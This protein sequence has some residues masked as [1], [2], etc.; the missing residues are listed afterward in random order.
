MS[1]SKPSKSNDSSSSDAPA[2]KKKDTTLA[3]LLFRLGALVLGVVVFFA[4]VGWFL[5][6]EYEVSTSIEIDAPPADVYALIGEAR[7]WAK[8]SPSW[9]FPAQ[10]K[11]SHRYFDNPP[12][13]SWQIDGT[14]GSF[15]RGK[16][17]FSD[18]VENQKVE[19]YV[20]RAYQVFN[21][22]ELEPLAD[23]TRTRVT[24]TNEATLPRQR[25]SDGLF[26]G[27]AGLV[28]K[29]ALK[30]Q[31]DADLIR[32]KNVCESEVKQ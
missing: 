21:S 22:I 11:V 19:Y 3:Q 30:G 9:D 23:G 32:L 1:A 31:Y 5:P 17:W 27:W 7:D 6:R 12:G 29:P 25:W 14:T 13:V 8:W 15:G 2:E 18:R 24:W 28:Y 16:M 10:E 20:E 26:Y 4:V